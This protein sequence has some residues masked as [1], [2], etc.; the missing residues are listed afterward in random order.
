[1]N[2]TYFITKMSCQADATSLDWR[3]STPP[4]RVSAIWATKLRFDR[5]LVRICSEFARP[6]GGPALY[7]D[8]FIGKEFD[9]IAALRVHDAEEAAFPAAEGEIAHRRRNAH[10][11]ANVTRTA[12][13]SFRV[14]FR[15]NFLT[16]P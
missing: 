8:L 9:R 5:L 13:R 4:I 15:K 1:M 10:V 11:H 14:P 3:D 12:G 16:V 7:D 6:L 2:K